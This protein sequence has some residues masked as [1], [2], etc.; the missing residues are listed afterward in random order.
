[1]GIETRAQA[2]MGD[3]LP[4]LPLPVVRMGEG[5]GEGMSL[6]LC[7]GLRGSSSLQREKYEQ[8][9]LDSR[10]SVN[11]LPAHSHPALRRLYV[12]LKVE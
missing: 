7:M 4:M 8:S 11:A 9:Q 6:T 2:S 12:A 3:R 10:R 1:M 5:I